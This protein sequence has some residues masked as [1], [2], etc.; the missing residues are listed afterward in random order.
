[1]S[2]TRVK[3]GNWSLG[4]KLTA[5]QMNALDTAMSE[6]L[7]KRSGQTDTLASNVTVTGTVALQGATTTTTTFDLT[8]A[9]S[10]IR[11]QHAS[12]KIQVAA[13]GAK[14][15]ANVSGASIVASVSGAKIAATA[16]GASIEA[17]ASGAK[18]AATVS[19]ASIEASASGA[20]IAATAS[21]ASIEANTGGAKIQT[22]TGGRI[23][24]GDNDYPQL[25]SGHT[26]RTVVRRVAPGAHA[27]GVSV[28]AVSVSTGPAAS[29][30][31]EPLNTTDFFRAFLDTRFK[32]ADTGSSTL[33]KAV[34][35]SL[36]EH[37]IDGATLT[38]VAVKLRVNSHATLPV[39]LPRIKV[40]KYTGSSVVLHSSGNVVVDPSATAADYSLDHFITATCDQN[41]VIDKSTAIY[42]LYLQNEGGTNAVAGV[43]CI[44]ILLTQTITELRP[45]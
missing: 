16:S 42:Y 29:E 8:G 2:H 45:A 28:A 34:L 31:I 41:N 27:V 6:C 5:A 32:S 18:I 26:G 15:D 3:P 11:L 36:N 40:A 25:A 21:G 23:E 43:N 35:W 24:L 14:V 17:N 19:G 13:S 44:D 30:E 37:L 39:A 22:L 1:M 38:S 7:D 4:E 9:S 20:K 12:S 10:V 33:S